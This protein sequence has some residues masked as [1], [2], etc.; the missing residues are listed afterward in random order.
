MNNY[1]EAFNYLQEFLPL[2]QSYVLHNFSEL[3]SR[4]QNNM[5]V[6]KYAYKFNTLLPNIVNKY[7]TKESISELYNKTCLFAKSLLLN[8]NIEMRKLI[9]ESGDPII[10]DKY[11]KLVSNISIY[12]KLMEKPIKER[13]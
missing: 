1:H 10:V 11:N 8:T 2:S 3:S 9:L 6:Y 13:L 7:Q 5:W 4:I 12:N